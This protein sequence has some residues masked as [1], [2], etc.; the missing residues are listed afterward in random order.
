MWNAF[1]MN[2]FI[3][4]RISIATIVAL[5]IH[6]FVTLADRKFFD[7]WIKYWRWAFLAFGSEK[8]DHTIVDIYY[9]ANESNESK[10]IICSIFDC[11]SKTL[12]PTRHLWNMPLSK[13][14]VSVKYIGA[15]THS[16][17]IGLK[18]PGGNFIIKVCRNSRF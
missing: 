14:E 5:L 15:E 18:Q 11:G 17:L 9:T 2:N 3:I 16:L 13:Q 1:G 7:F 4:I 12:K 10:Y 8:L 6:L